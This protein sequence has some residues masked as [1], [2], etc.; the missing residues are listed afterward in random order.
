M[1]LVCPN[2][3]SRYEIDDDRIGPAGRS[4]RCASCRTVFYAAPDVPVEAPQYENAVSDADDFAAFAA[5]DAPA[6][7]DFTEAPREDAFVSAQDAVDAAMAFDD[8]ADDGAETPGDEPSSS[9]QDV[10]VY[11]RDDTNLRSS[12]PV[13]AAHT[14]RPS[15]KKI[16]KAHYNGL[17]VA[18]GWVWRLIPAPVVVALVVTFGLGTVVIA[19]EQ[20]VRAVPQAASLY[21]L[22]GMP[23]NL[24]GLEFFNVS[25]T[26][27]EDGAARML[28]V[29]GDVANATKGLVEVSRVAFTIRSAA[30]DML[31][32][33]TIPAPRPALAPGESVSFSAR[34]ASPPA[35]GRHV[36][37]TFANDAA[38]T[39]GPAGGK[40]P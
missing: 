6:V 38:G 9:P 7:G 3:A 18:A 10:S 21:A 29:S 32:T 40:A 22:A 2:C 19:R 34:L 27:E 17:K 11:D 35:D 30:G 37:V 14:T 20:I 4:V 12:A 1:L 28:I 16:R 31:Y 24:R 8:T 36:L 39:M 26:I 25:S 13:I 5:A 15:R 23:V 33:W